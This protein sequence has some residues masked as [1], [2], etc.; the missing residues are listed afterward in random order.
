MF[1]VLGSLFGQGLLHGVGPDHCLAIGA[2]A[3]RGGLR[4]AVAV[5]VRFGL[6]HMAVLGVLATAAVVAG[7]VIPARW[8]SALE[9]V[10]GASLLALGCWTLLGGVPGDPTHHHG[11]GVMHAHDLVEHPPGAAPAP[12]PAARRGF[13]PLV[14]GALFGLS[15]VRSLVL[16]LPLMAQ[17]N[18]V[19]LVA[20]VGLFGLGVL[21]SMVLVGYLTQRIATAAHR[22]ERGLRVLVGLSSMACGAWWVVDHLG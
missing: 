7:V 10:G 6:G 4:R 12:A 16:A 21:L 9:V 13:F 15:G 2:L 1:I 20:G 18:P 22:V 11:D 17:R 19:V 8:E 14:A 3:S 5:S